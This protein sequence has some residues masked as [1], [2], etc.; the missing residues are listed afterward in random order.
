LGKL[1]FSTPEHTAAAGNR[2]PDAS[3][4]WQHASNRLAAPLCVFSFGMI[5]SSSFSIF[6][7]QFPNEEIQIGN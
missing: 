3:A 6:N 2:C 5:H 4:R 7:C 1:F